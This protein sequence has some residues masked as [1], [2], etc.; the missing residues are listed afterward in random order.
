MTAPPAS[1]RGRRPRP[2]AHHLGFVGVEAAAECDDIPLESPGIRRRFPS[3]AQTPVAGSKLP[4]NSHSAGPVSTTRSSARHSTVSR[5][6]GAMIETVRP[7]RPVRAATAAAQ[8][9]EP[10]AFVRPAPR[11]Q[12]RMVELILAC[13]LGDG[14]VGALRK[15]RVV[16]Q[17]RAEA[18]E[19]VGPG[20]RGRPRISRADC[21][22]RPRRAEIKHGRVD[23]ADPQLDRARVVELLGKRNIAQ[24]D[25]QRAQIDR[26]RAVGMFLGIENAGDRL[27]GGESL[28]RFPPPA[29]APRSACRCRRPARTNRRN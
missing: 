27:E 3:R 19:V 15:D 23:R 10:Q 25:L 2:R 11:S 22:W 6:T 21:P 24:A 1:V 5:P 12:V 16:F 17:H 7:V 26:D 18:V 4:E 13:R 29:T 20:P 9:A 8:A 14:D 28:R